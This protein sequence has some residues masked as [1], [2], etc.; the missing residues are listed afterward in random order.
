MNV[1]ICGMTSLEMTRGVIACNP[2]HIG[3]VFAK[4]RRQVS[5]DTVQ[6]IL[7]QLENEQ[8]HIPHT[9]GVFA[10][11]DTESLKPVMKSCTVQAL[12]FHAN[13]QLDICGW[14]KE[15]SNMDVWLTLPISNVGK[16]DFEDELNHQFERLAKAAPYIDLLLLDTHD[17]VQGGGS[18]KVF[19][20]D[21]IPF[22]QSRAQQLGM[23]LYVAGGLNP[24]NIGSLLS[25][26]EL[27]G[28]DVSS[29]VE[30]DGI[31]DMSKVDT[32][33]GRVRQH[34]HTRTSLPLS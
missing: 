10:N 6:S 31:K 11:A 2:D 26:Y 33:I 19:Q 25:G 8:V 16:I 23:P 27:D 21:V 34:V 30:T 24:G 15:N 5:P 9:V 14:V 28:V 7:N 22:Y 4:S 13:E 20:W 18:G 29:G 3:F 12:Q 17:P 32:F 1:K